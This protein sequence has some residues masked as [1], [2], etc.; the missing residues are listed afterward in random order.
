MMQ[1]IKSSNKP[2]PKTVHS[3]I[4]SYQF[5]AIGTQWWIGLYE[6]VSENEL[7]AMQLRIAEEIEQY[8]AV[9]SRFRDDSVITHI[10]KQAGDYVL[11]EHAN[12]LIGLY[13]RLYDDTD[14]SMTPLIGQTLVDAGYDAHYSLQSGPQRTVLGWPEVAKLDNSVLSITQPAWL[15]FGAA[16]KGQLVDIISSLIEDTGIRQYCVDASGDLRMRQPGSLRI[17]LEHP[18][19]PSKAIGVAIVQNQSICGSA[20][21]RRAW[22]NYHHIIDAK[23]QQPVRDIVA[24]WVIADTTIMA[25][26][27]ATALFFSEPQRLTSYGEFAWVIMKSDNSVSASNNFNGELFNAANTR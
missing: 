23:N 19:D 1:S 25:D 2:K 18:E 20:S 12:E 21:N 7:Q 5:A 24:V 16:G 17:G 14:G 13:D 10:A 26:A 22:G 8:D 4:C 11:P 3:P 6:H 15:D 27:L 9:Y